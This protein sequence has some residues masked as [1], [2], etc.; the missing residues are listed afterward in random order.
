MGDRAFLAALLALP[1]SHRALVLAMSP[2]LLR[3]VAAFVV[4]DARIDDATWRLQ[5]T[6]E[7]AGEWLAQVHAGLIHPR[8]L[9]FRFLAELTEDFRH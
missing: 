6:C 3:E 5:A 4:R 2:L 9:L 1:Y 8:N 7:K